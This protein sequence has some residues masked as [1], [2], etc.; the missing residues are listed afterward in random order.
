MTTK[1]NTTLLTGLFFF[2]LLTG[3]QAQDKYD[4]ATVT[5]SNYSELRISIEGKPF[6]VRQLPKG[7]KYSED[8]G[9]LF[10]YI[11]KMQNDGWEVFNTFVSTFDVQQVTFVLR[12][13]KS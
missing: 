9:K 1:F 6:E 4:F 13:K 8:H 2:G 12:K 3:L 11:A 10:E 7:T 5:Q